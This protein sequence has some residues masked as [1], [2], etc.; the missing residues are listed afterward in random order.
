MAVIAEAFVPLDSSSGKKIQVVESNVFAV[1]L[2]SLWGLS[3]LAAEVDNGTLRAHTVLGTTDEMGSVSTV[4]SPKS[5][6]RGNKMFLI[7]GSQKL[8]SKNATEC[9]PGDLDIFNWL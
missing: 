9:V 3:S 4:S 2:N 1:Y 8:H 5:V 7:A 6:S